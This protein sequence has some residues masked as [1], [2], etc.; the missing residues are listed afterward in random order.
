MKTLLLVQK[1]QRVI[2]DTLYE[3]IE[4]EISDL[5]IYKMTA[6]EQSSL[7]DFFSRIS[8]QEYDRIVFF[9]RFKKEIQQVS[10]IRTI[11]NLVILEHDAYQNYIDCKYKGKFSKHYRALPWSRII[12]SGYSV[13]KKLQSENFD[14]VFVPKGYDQKLLSNK[15]L[16]RDIELAF[17]GS[18]EHKTY[19]LRKKWL[20]QLKEEEN[21]QIVRTASGEDYCK[22]LNR[23]KFFISADI[24]FGE[25]MIKNFEAMACGCVLFSYNQGEDENQALGFVDMEN[26]VLYSSL[27]ELKHKLNILR[28]KPEKALSISVNGQILAEREY[29]FDKIGKKIAEALAPP[30]RKKVTK[31]IFGIKRFS[32]ELPAT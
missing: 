27:D 1:E 6:T 12:S 19:R 21:L 5:T 7:K 8:Y 17:L 30:L 23:I 25:Y 22:A 16:E 18:I 24:G 10:F 28:K 20:L 15:K 13:T 2:L 14:A 11:P 32:Y 9:L 3:A 26:I 4:R 29:S 31:A